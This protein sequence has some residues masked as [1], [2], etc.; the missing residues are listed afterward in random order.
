VKAKVV[1]DATGEADVAMRAGA[2]MIY[3]KSSYYDLDK[4][5]PGGAGVHCVV[6]GVDCERYRAYVEEQK[7]LLKA[8]P[9]LFV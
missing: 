1:I 7:E 6:G 2:P 9:C 8:D 4:H 5:G 3:P